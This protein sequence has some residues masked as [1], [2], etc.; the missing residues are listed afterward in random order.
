MVATHRETKEKIYCSAKTNIVN[1]WN[2]LSSNY[3]MPCLHET[4]LPR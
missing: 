1:L 4:R 2:E 3:V